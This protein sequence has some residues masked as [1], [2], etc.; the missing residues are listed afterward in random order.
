MF[1]KLLGVEERF[2]EVEKYLSDPK[3]VNDRDAYQ[4]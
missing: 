2:I 3:I 1:D 4:T